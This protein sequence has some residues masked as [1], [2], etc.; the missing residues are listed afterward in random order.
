MRCTAA[1]YGVVP[2]DLGFTEDVNR[3]HSADTE[4]LSEFGWRKWDE[5][6]PGEKIATV[7]PTTQALE[8]HIP[9]TLHTSHFDGELINFKSKNVDVAVTPN[10]KMWIRTR[11]NEVAHNQNVKMQGVKE[12]R[13]ARKLSALKMSQQLGISRTTIRL[14]EDGGKVRPTTAEKIATL[15]PEVTWYW[16]E[17]DWPTWKKVEAQEIARDGVYSPVW[18][19]D[20]VVW[21]NSSNDD[22]N[23]VFILPE[24]QSQSHKKPARAIDMD[25]W[26][27]FLGYVI[28]EGCVYRSKD[29]STQRNRYIVTLSQSEKVNFA[30]VKKIQECLDLLPFNF[31][32]YLGKDG[33]RTWQVSDKALWTWLSENIGHLSGDKKL[34]DMW[35]EFD[36]RQLHILLDAL[37]LGDGTIDKRVNN[38]NFTYFTK[39]TALA[40][41]VQEVALRLGYRA[42]IGRG[43]GVYRISMDTTSS[44]GCRI[45]SRNI[46]KMPYSGTVWCFDVPPN[47]LFI[48]RRNGKIGIHGNST[49][50]IQ[51]D[52]QFR[53]GTLPIVRFV[54]SVLNT[55][56]QYHLGLQARI[57]FDTG[58]GTQH[59]LERAQADDIYIKNGTLSNDEVRMKLGRRISK[60]NP[61]PRIFDN[62]R[63][64]PIPLS[65]IIAVSQDI[66]ATT[67]GPTNDA[68]KPNFI[69]IPPPGV[70]PP[71][72]SPDDKRAGAISSNLYSQTLGGKGNSKAKGS[73]ASSTAPTD[74]TLPSSPST[75]STSSISSLTQKDATAGITTATGA[76]GVDLMSMNKTPNKPKSQTNNNF[77]KD[78]SEDEESP[79]PPESTKKSEVKMVSSDDPLSPY[80]E[81]LSKKLHQWRMN[82]INRVKKNLTPRKFD[83]IPKVVSDAIWVNLSKAST[84]DQVWECFSGDVF[85]DVFMEKNTEEEIPDPIVAG[86]A[87]VAQDTNKVVMVQ[88]GNKHD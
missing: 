73:L 8:Y 80:V 3:C 59:R 67:Y 34:P 26:I 79:E 16:D 18:F 69:P 50:E 6:V 22:S 70:L 7:N 9:T 82:S 83:D 58:Q 54:E 14:V 10:H 28:S 19:A 72:A 21:E 43:T 68:L 56:T 30:K 41:D 13:L 64:G 25:T 37:M 31:N 46:T 5:W 87:L 33:G 17:P 84:P 71:K 15:L 1:A 53:V 63:S 47:R 4:Y 65:S 24:V 74:S 88:R 62:T 60:K 27:E 44:L 86:I 2:N 23:S 38:S 76:T 20:S 81:D 52:V 32:S 48:T 75:P 40:N 55:F 66:D 57:Q 85:G 77:P 78:Y 45:Q 49:G 29:I 39:S 51:V 61:V 35:K 12:A 36:K 11:S 42:Q